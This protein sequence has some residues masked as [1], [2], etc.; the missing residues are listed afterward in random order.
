MSMAQQPSFL[1]YLREL[2]AFIHSTARTLAVNRNNMHYKKRSNQHAMTTRRMT[3]TRKTIT[4]VHE[5]GNVVGYEG[6]NNYIGMHTN[7][8]F[9]SLL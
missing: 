8:C 6:S 2:L 5:D 4:K 9:I 3:T 1:I 7:S